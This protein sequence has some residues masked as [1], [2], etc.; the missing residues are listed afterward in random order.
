MGGL[1]ICFTK[2]NHITF[3]Y[4]FLAA[5]Q[6]MNNFPVISVFGAG[7]MGAAFMLVIL[8]VGVACYLCG[9]KRAAERVG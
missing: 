8:G 4:S 7:L 5:G 6:L 3:S 1:L 9:E 2:Y